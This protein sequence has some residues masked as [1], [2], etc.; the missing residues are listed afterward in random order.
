MDSSPHLGGTPGA[1]TYAVPSE[2]QPL[3]P[4]DLAAVTGGKSWPEWRDELVHRG[5][6][7]A[8]AYGVATGC[9][10]WTSLKLHGHF[11][12]PPAR[13]W[14]TWAPLAASIVCS[15]VVGAGLNEVVP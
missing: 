7:N 15:T 11:F 14:K 8:G 13:G 12:V 3:Q 10:G 5:I 2:P 1:S 6:V 4:V 9:Y